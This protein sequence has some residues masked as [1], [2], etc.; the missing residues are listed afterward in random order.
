MRWYKMYSSEF[1]FT[2][3]LQSTMKIKLFSTFFSFWK[4]WEKTF[5]F[6][7]WLT[8][9][10]LGFFVFSALN[11]HQSELE[12]LY[13]INYQA[14]CIFYLRHA[15]FNSLLILMN[16]SKEWR[17][18]QARNKF[19]FCKIVHIMCKLD[20]QTTKFSCSVSWF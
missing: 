6:V 4:G 9:A 1:F 17:M 12:G 16:C 11:A 5:F 8:Q 7:V 10:C 2:K 18:C 13:C 19:K 3:V 15:T 14:N 20:V